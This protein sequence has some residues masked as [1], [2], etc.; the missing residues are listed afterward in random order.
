MRFEIKFNNQLFAKKI[1]QVEKLNSQLL[2]FYF[3]KNKIA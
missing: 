1:N 2:K 3:T